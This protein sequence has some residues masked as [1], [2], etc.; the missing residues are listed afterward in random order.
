MLTS[1]SR[2][3]LAHGVTVFN[4]DQSQASTGNSDQSQASMRNFDQSQPF[5]GNMKKHE[6]IMKEYEENMK[7]YE[8]N[9]KEIWKKYEII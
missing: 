3:K 7:K 5:V 6:E 8:G 1:W 9:M 4:F 2:G